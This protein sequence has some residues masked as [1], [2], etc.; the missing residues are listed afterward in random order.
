MAA[1]VLLLLDAFRYDY[2]SEDLTP[3]LWKCSQEGEYYDGVEP[4]M[5]FCERSEI[6]TGLRPNKT[7]FFT[8]IGFDPLNSP[9]ANVSILPWLDSFERILVQLLRVFPKVFASRLQNKFRYWIAQYFLSLGIVMPTYL[10]PFSW[11]RY[12]ALTEDQVDHRLPDAFPEKSIL[13]LLDEA[14]KSYFYETFSALGMRSKYSSDADRFSAVIRDGKVSVK[15]LYLIYVAAADTYGHFYGPDSPKFRELLTRL[16]REIECFVRDFESVAP[17]TRYLVVGDHGMTN[18]SVKFDALSEIKGLLKYVKLLPGRDVIYF[19]DSTMIRFWFLNDRARRLL[20]GLLMEA[21][22]FNDNGSWMNKSIA[23]QYHLPWPDI[24]YGELLWVAN[25]G[26]LVFPDFF[27]NFNP[28]LGMHGYDTSAHESW[29]TCLH[30]GND[31]HASKH[32]RIPLTNI[33]SILKKSLQI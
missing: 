26:V 19:L 22:G 7:G 28:C 15:D 14:G 3:F 6:L 1:T 12:F 31:I 18:V 8:A 27:H 29:G 17:N 9:Y 10:I 25:P 11:L 33:F 16:D 13:T 4:S 23:V 5:G 32:S 30:W 2:I 21:K 24:R 20:T